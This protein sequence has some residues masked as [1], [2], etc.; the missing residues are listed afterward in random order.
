MTDKEEK[1]ARDALKY[2]MIF[3][4]AISA[5]IWAPMIMLGAFFC[6]PIYLIY[7]LFDETEEDRKEKENTN[8]K[9][10]EEKK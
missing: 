1:L 8:K 6:L 7:L 3:M 4:L 5:P 10:C 2:G 9:L